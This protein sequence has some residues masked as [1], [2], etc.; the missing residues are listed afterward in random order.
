ASSSSGARLTEQADHSLLASGGEPGSE[1]Y[2]I[3]AKA[4]LSGITA[5]RL[6]ALPDASLP[7][8]GPGRDPYGI[9]ALNGIDV[10]AYP[11]ATPAAKQRAA[12]GDAF[13]DDGDVRS[14]L[15]NPPGG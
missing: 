2:T 15:R 14:L 7:R 10:E 5:I 4:G 11:A 12:I 13:A 9:F 8:V 3:T 1:T 6:E